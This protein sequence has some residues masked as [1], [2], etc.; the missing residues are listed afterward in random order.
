MQGHR[1]GEKQVV[2]IFLLG[3]Q[4][5]WLSLSFLT[6]LE[7]RGFILISE[8]SLLPVLG[9]PQ[10]WGNLRLKWDIER[11][12]SGGTCSPGRQ[13]DQISLNEHHSPRVPSS[14]PELLPTAFGASVTWDLLGCASA[15]LLS[16][17]LCLLEDAQNERN[18]N[19]E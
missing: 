17:D 4:G 2:Q 8:A 14:H 3:W 1:Q 12:L 13:F 7:L 10:Y 5:L 11:L 16:R 15:T 6:S 19:T 18:P 9:K